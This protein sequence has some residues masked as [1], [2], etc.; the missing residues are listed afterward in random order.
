MKQAAL[1]LRD[2]T[3]A[4][5]PP[6][7]A[8]RTERFEAAGPVGWNERL[9]LAETLVSFRAPTSIE[10]DQYRKLRHVVERFRRES[11]SQVFA[12]T[13]AIPGDGKT[14]TALNLAGS[15][16]QAEDAR[17]LIICADLHRPSIPKYL[18]ISPR[19]PGLADAVLRDGY[20]LPETV[21]R[22]NSLNI[23][24]LFSGDGEDRAYEV[25]ASPALESLLV[26][27]RR[28][29]DYVII[30][31]PPVLALVDTGVLGRV[32]DGFIVVV[33]ANRTPRK[34]LAEALRQLQPWKILGL[35]FNGDDRP[36]TPYYG[37][38]GYKY[39]PIRPGTRRS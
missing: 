18:G 37:Y 27:A 30:D 14:V 35:V 25:L 16:A 19:G 3:Q 32:V 39:S 17:V 11:G 7:K 28:A 24:V 1:T 13:S 10:A 9:A 5:G 21:R 26:Q 20:G 6:V 36:L 2:V 29:Y 15:L 8:P 22:L 31:T 34:V 12:I 23:S 38:Y 33:A 4:D